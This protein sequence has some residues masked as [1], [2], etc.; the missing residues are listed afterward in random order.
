MD[1]HKVRV[2]ITQGDINGIGYEVIIKAFMDPREF[3]M[4]AH[5]WYMVPQKFWPT[6]ARH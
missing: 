1:E 6:I 5:R 4:S 2:G 3:W